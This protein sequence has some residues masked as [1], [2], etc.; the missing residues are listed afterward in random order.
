[1]NPA[2]RL[3]P[4]EAAQAREIYPGSIFQRRHHILL[5]DRIESLRSQLESAEG[6]EV[7][8]LQAQIV[9]VRALLAELHADD[10]DNVKKLYESR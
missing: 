3:S 8:K 5:S 7:L 4:Q 10:S 1:M 2:I 6:H 9:A